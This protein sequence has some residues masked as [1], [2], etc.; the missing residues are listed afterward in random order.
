MQ[1]E[2][3]YEKYHFECLCGHYEHKFEII[4]DPDIDDTDN[5]L[6]A[7]VSLNDGL[8]WYKRVYL[9]IRYIFGHTSR[10]GHYAEFLL[11]RDDAKRMMEVCKKFLDNNKS[12]VF[13]IKTKHF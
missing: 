9:A 13:P 6:Y 7:T 5:P 10:Y 1:K 12:N 8:P 4:F 3:R 11:E 2:I